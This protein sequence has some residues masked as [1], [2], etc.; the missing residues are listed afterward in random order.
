[1][2]KLEYEKFKEHILE[3]YE[4]PEELSNEISHYQ[5]T[6][7]EASE[8]I[9]KAADVMCQYGCFDVYYSQVLETLREVYGDE[10]N[11]DKYI[12]KGG[13]IR[14]KNNEAYCWTIYKAKIARTIYEMYKKGEL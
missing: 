12:T 11:G 10:Y 5:A 8:N 9:F 14:F 4:T 13:E 1:M 7:P 6:I 3:Y 2:R